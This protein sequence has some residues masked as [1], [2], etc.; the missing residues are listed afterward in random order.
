MRSIVAVAALGLLLGAAACGGDT[1]PQTQPS[2]DKGSGKLEIWADPKRTAALKPFAEQF[3]KENGVQVEVKEIAENLQQTFVTASQQGSGPDVV[4]GAHDWIGNLVQNSAIDPVN[5][6]AAQKSGFEASALKAVTF[7]GQVYGAPYAMENLAL[8]RNTELVPTA[9]ASIEDLVK[10]GQDLKAAGKVSE[11]LCLQVGA[12]GDAYHIYPFFASA[13]GSLFG[14]T[15]SGDPDPKNVTVGSADSVKAFTKL[16][17]LGEQGS[18]ALKTSIAAENSIASFA[19]KKCAFLVSGP[20]A[21][22]DIKAGGVKYDISAVPGFAGG[23]KA[24]PFL[25][26]Q[27]FFVA[28]KAK[29]KALAQEFVANY[30]TN[31]DVAKALYDAEPRPPA[32]TAAIAVVKTSDPDLEKFL[33]AG[34]DG[35]PM[36]AIPEMAAIWGPFGQA[37]VA[38]VKGEDPSTAAAAAQTAI[39]ATLKK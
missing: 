25:G 16:K 33:A 10:A 5:L 23:K 3:G 29:S 6:T 24:T 22:K 28:S 20:W 2:K 32:L 4:V 37:E 8:I 13:G 15:S 35:F 39:L 38:V 9:P 21:T 7:N 1:T 19:G 14:S 11:I 31:K 18:G 30:V 12:Q 34:K 17:E 26:V 27:A 36:P